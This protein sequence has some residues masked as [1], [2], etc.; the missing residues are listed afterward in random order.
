M[1]YRY[2]FTNKKQWRR[3][4]FELG[5]AFDPERRRRE[6]AFLG[7][8]GYTFRKILNL[9]SRKRHFRQFKHQIQGK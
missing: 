4:L 1:Y 7:G 2:K 9:D 8:P 3:Q 6:V 5:H